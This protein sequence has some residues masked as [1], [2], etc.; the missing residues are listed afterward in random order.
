[1]KSLMVRFII[2]YSRWVFLVAK[3]YYHGLRLRLMVWCYPD[4]AR[5]V[6]LRARWFGSQT[7]D[8]ELLN[9]AEILEKLLAQRR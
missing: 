5:K 8:I 2:E 3:Q 1:M 9:G 4:V 6:A 7:D